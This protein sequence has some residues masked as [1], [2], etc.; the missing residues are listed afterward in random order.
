MNKKLFSIMLLL[1]LSFSLFASFAI[2]EDD[3]L[4]SSVQLRTVDKTYRISLTDEGVVKWL[5]V[6]KRVHINLPG[7]TYSFQPVESPTADEFLLYLSTE[8]YIAKFT[9]GETKTFDLDKDG[10]NDMSVTYQDFSPGSGALLFA[11]IPI[12]EANVP[13]VTP[14]VTQDTPEVTSNDVNN[15]NNTISSSDSVNSTTTDSSSS[16]PGSSSSIPVYIWILGGFVILLIAYFVFKK[17][18]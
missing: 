8:K 13:Q 9:M 4:A 15:S 1:L 17:K 2:A 12:E 3:I 16:L 10:V 7:V 14:Q 5:N 18:K 6:K 11:S